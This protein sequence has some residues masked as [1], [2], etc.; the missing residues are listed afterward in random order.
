MKNKLFALTL[1]STFGISNTFNIPTVEAQ[2][3]NVYRCVMKN[4]SPTTVVD[5]K[6]GRIDLIVWKSNLFSGWSPLK[7][8]QAITSRFQ[9][10]SDQGALRY[11]T[12]GNINNQPAIC[13]A[14]NIPG[15]GISCRRNG[16]L[17]TLQPNDN[18]QKVMNDLFDLSARVRGGS[19]VTRSAE[20]QSI[21]AI[22]KFLEEVDVSEE[23]PPDNLEGMGNN[24]TENPAPVPPQSST[25]NNSV[26]TNNNSAPQNTSSNVTVIEEPSSSQLPT[27]EQSS[28]SNPIAD[29]LLLTLEPKDNPQMQQMFSYQRASTQQVAVV[30]QK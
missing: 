26:I 7:R 28:I 30:R 25:P 12:T 20:G 9:E 17:I 15:R 19:P 27:V 13:V 24:P 16:L 10:F 22:D 3:R 29:G 21:L 23:I 1:V 18:P 5:T 2:T 14:Q 11:V 6:R 4:G 8:C